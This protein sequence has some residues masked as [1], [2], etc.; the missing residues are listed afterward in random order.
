MYPGT[1]SVKHSSKQTNLP[2]LLKGQT[3]IGMREPIIFFMVN[4]TPFK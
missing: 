1:S 4:D 3:D 2:R